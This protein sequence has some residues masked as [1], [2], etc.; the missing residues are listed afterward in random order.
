MRSLF[1]ATLA[2]AAYVSSALVA[3]QKADLSPIVTQSLVDAI[4]SNP[5][6]T[7]KAAMPTGKHEAINRREIRRYLGVREETEEDK[8]LFAATPMR[9]FTAAEKAMDIPEEF[10]ASKQ[11]PNCPTI[12]LIPDQSDCGSCWA[13]A[14]A[15]AMSDRYCISGQYRNLSISALDLLSCGWGMG[16]NGGNPLLAWAYWADKGLVS[17]ECQPYPFACGKAGQ[18]PCP[19]KSYATPECLNNCS[20]NNGTYTKYYGNS[21]YVIWGEENYQREI[22]TNGPIEIGFM[23]YEDFLSYK[24]GIYTHTEGWMLGGHAVRMVGWGVQDGVKYWKL[25][26]SWGYDWGMDGYFLMKRGTNECNVEMSGV[27]GLVRPKN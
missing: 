8:K 14:G 7:W 12:P 27:G 10:D 24:S 16:C 19:E 25:A 20:S 11:W 2:A 5:K 21:S 13:V 26:N 6:A 9:Q 3:D 17:E 23:V 18:P 22:M 1:V 15:S 4:N